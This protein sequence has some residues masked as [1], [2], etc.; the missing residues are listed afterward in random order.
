MK[1]SKADELEKE[2]DGVKGLAPTPKNEQFDVKK[3]IDSLIDTDFG[4]SN[5]EQGKAVQ[6]LKGM[7][8][9]DDPL[10]NKFM[11]AVSKAMDSLNKDDFK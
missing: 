6:L 1:E 10:S 7:A 5:E 11:A 2:M 4:G 9:S 8:F 3:A